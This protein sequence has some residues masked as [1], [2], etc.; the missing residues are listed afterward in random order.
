V[1]LFSPAG[2]SIQTTFS[3]IFRP[4]H[5]VFNIFPQIFSDEKI[6][7]ASL[8]VRRKDLESLHAFMGIIYLKSCWLSIHFFGEDGLK[9]WVSKCYGVLM[10]SPSGA[11]QHLTTRMPQAVDDVQLRL[12]TDAQI[13]DVPRAVW[14]KCA[15]KHR[16][17]V[18]VLFISRSN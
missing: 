18:A 9:S 13:E 16:S 1:P 7:N 17:T 5:I 3:S 8:L 12:L 11:H 15:R 6:W 2:R 10:V 4:P 14:Q